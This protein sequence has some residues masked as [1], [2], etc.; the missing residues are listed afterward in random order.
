MSTATA[1]GIAFLKERITTEHFIKCIFEATYVQG[2]RRTTREEITL[3]QTIMFDPT[4]RQMSR[5]KLHDS[6]VKWANNL[7]PEFGTKDG[8]K[9]YLITRIYGKYQIQDDKSD[10]EKIWEEDVKVPMNK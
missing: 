10:W 7:W 5:Q 4:K 1:Q 2:A 9:P 3:T 8:S 6:L